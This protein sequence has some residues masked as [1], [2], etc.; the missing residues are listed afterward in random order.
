MQGV[1][2][3]MQYSNYVTI[4]SNQSFLLLILFQKYEKPKF[5]QCLA[6]LGNG[7]VLTGDSGGIILI[8]GKTTVEAT[9]GKGVKG[10]ICWELMTDFPQSVEDKHKGWRQG[11]NRE[12]GLTQ[13]MHFL[14]I[15]GGTQVLQVL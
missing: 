5:V 4:T 7:D 12:T 14:S 11:R 2:V 13:S 3:W 9:P 6:F 8:W 15:T 1:R 10:R